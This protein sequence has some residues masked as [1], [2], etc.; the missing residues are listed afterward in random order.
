MDG[1]TGKWKKNN[2]I[3]PFWYFV[4]FDNHPEGLFRYQFRKTPHQ[5]WVV[6]EFRQSP[7][8]IP[9]SMEDNAGVIRIH[10]VPWN[11]HPDTT[12][13]RRERRYIHG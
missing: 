6:S 4:N 8:P 3:Y 1:E 5:R 12:S 13:N 7:P 11:R 10:I 9:G 2:N